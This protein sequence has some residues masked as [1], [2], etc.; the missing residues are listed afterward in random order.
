MDGQLMSETT[1]DVLYYRGGPAGR[2]FSHKYTETWKK[3]EMYCPSCGKQ[4]VWQ[5]QSSG[6]YYVG[7]GYICVDCESCWTIQGPDKIHE[8][9]EQGQQRLNA[10]PALSAKESL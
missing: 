4:E 8:K 7:E 6:D 1:F 3:I 10:I 5:E 9:D 2:A